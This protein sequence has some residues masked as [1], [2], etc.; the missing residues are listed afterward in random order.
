MS[1]PNI[2]ITPTVPAPPPVG[3]PTPQHGDPGPH[4]VSVQKMPTQ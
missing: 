3:S 4:K 1:E 2:P